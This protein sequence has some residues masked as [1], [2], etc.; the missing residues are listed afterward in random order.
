MKAK[1]AIQFS[2]SAIE[3]VPK[4]GRKKKLKHETPSSE[5][6]TAGLDPHD[7]ATKRTISNKLRA[8][9]VGLTWPPNTLRTAVAAAITTTAATYP[10]SGLWAS[11]FKW[12]I[13]SWEGFE[14]T[15][16]LLKTLTSPR[17]PSKC[18][19]FRE[20]IKISTFQEFFWRIELIASLT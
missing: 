18:R 5:A 11:F 6:S 16:H 1:K 4:G 15:S 8:T 17:P 9:V 3:N 10:S 20:N 7:V 19:S 13:V 2:G 14:T 12:L